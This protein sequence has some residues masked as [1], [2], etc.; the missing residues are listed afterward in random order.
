[1]AQ[2]GDGAA[3]WGSPAIATSG[4]D[5][6]EGATVA[7][8]ERLPRTKTSV[9]PPLAPPAPAAR[10]RHPHYAAKIISSLELQFWIPPQ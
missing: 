4:H 8:R 9:T 5:F 1:M 10:I 3:W 7:I 6:T 2:A